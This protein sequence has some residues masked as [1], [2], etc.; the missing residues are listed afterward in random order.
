V[1]P[2]RI[3]LYYNSSR[4]CFTCSSPLSTFDLYCPPPP[5]YYC[6]PLTS[7]G[8]TFSLDYLVFRKLSPLYDVFYPRPLISRFK[9]AF[10]PPT[11]FILFCNTKQFFYNDWNFYCPV[12]YKCCNCKIISSFC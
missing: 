9:L 8:D 11:R 12:L 2:L 10:S 4:N 1:I 6:Q 7:A 5:P 3:N